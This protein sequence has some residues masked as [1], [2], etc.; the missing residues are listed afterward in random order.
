MAWPVILAAQLCSIMANSR[1][2]LRNCSN[3]KGLSDRFVRIT[4][5]GP[6]INAMVAD[7]LREI[8][9]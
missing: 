7:K 2:L 1:V 9:A 4:L 3:F 5:K 6:E 8:F